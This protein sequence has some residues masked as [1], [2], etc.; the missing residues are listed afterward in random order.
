MAFD[1]GFVQH[2]IDN[3]PKKDDMVALDIG[4]NVG[5]Y[6]VPLSKKFKKV[7]AIEANPYTCESLKENIKGADIKNVE[8]V[9]CAIC[10]VDQDVKL[11][12]VGKDGACAGGNTLAFHVARTKQWGHDID[13]FVGVHGLTL[14]SFI[15]EKKIKKL[16]FIKMDIEGAEDFAW[17][18]AVNTLNNF[19]LDIVLE[20]HKQVNYPRL[21]QLFKYHK[22]RIFDSKV[23]EPKEFQYDS[24]YLI[25]NRHGTNGSIR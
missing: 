14:D 10:D 24:H 7:Y 4:A 15:K 11:Y 18:G 16:R 25:T 1:E 2:I 12:T 23:R 9:N 20:V 3:Y 17:K 19:Q 22:Y 21:F 5:K 8:V 6:T 13:N